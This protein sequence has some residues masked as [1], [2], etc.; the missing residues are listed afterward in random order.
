MDPSIIYGPEKNNISK[1]L[2][3]YLQQTNG[4]EFLDTSRLQPLHRVRHPSWAFADAP[5]LHGIRP[6]QAQA[7]AHH[8]IVGLHHALRPS[9]LARMS[10]TPLTSSAASASPKA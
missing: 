10:P 9:S 2:K 3:K 4:P 5:H 6:S 7:L 1:N 8:P